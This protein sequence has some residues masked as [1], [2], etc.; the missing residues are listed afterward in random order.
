MQS[1]QIDCNVQ[2]AF[3]QE[4]TGSDE[5]K[6]NHE[7]KGK[8]RRNGGQDIKCSIDC[9][10]VHAVISAKPLWPSREMLTSGI[11]PN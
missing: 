4:M 11:G 7:G 8:R 1:Q 5:P 3:M 9:F 10:V 6:R 2:W